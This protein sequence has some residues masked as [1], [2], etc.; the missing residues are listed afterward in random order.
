MGYWNLRFEISDQNDKGK[1]AEMSNLLDIATVSCILDMVSCM[2]D[3]RIGEIWK[4]GDQ[5]EPVI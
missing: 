4:I 3:I 1:G 2:L 5:Y